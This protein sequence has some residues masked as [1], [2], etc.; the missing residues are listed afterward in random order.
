L[1]SK[2]S[3]RIKTNVLQLVLQ[4]ISG[5]F[6][7]VFIHSVYA[8]HQTL[9]PK[10]Y[11]RRKNRKLRCVKTKYNFVIYSILQ[12]GPLYFNYIPTVFYL[13]IGFNKLIFLNTTA[14]VTTQNN[15]NLKLRRIGGQ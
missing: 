7:G 1:D 6:I 14:F 11:I 9:G 3:Q 12:Y 13:Q 8:T 2:H 4:N 5:R 15:S 10:M